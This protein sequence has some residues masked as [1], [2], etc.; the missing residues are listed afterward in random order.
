MRI[1]KTSIPTTQ[2]YPIW[3]F[4]DNDSEVVLLR[5]PDDFDQPITW[6]KADI[7]QLPRT[8]IKKK[9]D[10][11]AESTMGQVWTTYRWFE[12]GYR[13][14]KEQSESTGCCGKCQDKKSAKSPFVSPEEYWNEP[15]ESAFDERL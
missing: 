10:E 8:H 11:I 3:A 6:C 9:F 5:N 12:A 7:P 1:W 13:Y 14:G 2:D 4:T 15:N